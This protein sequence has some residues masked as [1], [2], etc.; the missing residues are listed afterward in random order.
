MQNKSISQVWKTP[1][2][3]LIT[4][5]NIDQYG[6]I[7]V[8]CYFPNNIFLLYKN[9]TSTGKN[10][11]TKLYPSFISVDQKE[12]IIVNGDGKLQLFF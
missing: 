10:L 6:Y 7:M 11:T 3:G 2:T 1:C 8:S 9:G 4:S 12:R 5:I